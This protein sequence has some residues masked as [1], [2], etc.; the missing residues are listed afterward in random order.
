MSGSAG[1]VT[2]LLSELRGGSQEAANRLVPL[3]YEWR[4]A[5]A[6]LSHDAA[7]ANSA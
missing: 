1:S 6:W 4:W 7:A 3:V 2:R 5:K